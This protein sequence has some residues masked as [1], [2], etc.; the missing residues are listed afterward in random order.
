MW[1][2]TL[3][4]GTVAFALAPAPARAELIAA[5]DRPGPGGDLDIALVA[6]TTG[7]QIA[8]PA[9]I[10]TSADE[11]HP[12]LSGDG[13]LLTFERATPAGT[14]YAGADANAAKADPLPPF[15][16]ASQP[17]KQILVVDIHSGAR[18]QPTVL[19]LA[20]RKKITPALSSDAR[21]LIHG[22]TTGGE[23][24]SARVT[25]FDVSGAP[26]VPPETQIDRTD[27]HNALQSPAIGTGA[28]PLLA[29]S[30]LQERLGPEMPLSMAAGFDPAVGGVLAP[31]FKELDRGTDEGDNHP[32]ILSNRFVAYEQTPFST[33]SG[34][35][36]SGDIRGFDVAT[37]QPLTLVPGVNT[38]GDERMPA[39][40]AD[41]R[42]FTWVHHRADDDHDEL[43]TYDFATG[44]L[45][46][47][48]PADLGANPSRTSSGIFRR[49]QGNVSIADD[50]TLTRQVILVGTSTVVCHYVATGGGSPPPPKGGAPVVIERVVYTQVCTLKFGVRVAGTTVKVGFLVQRI[51]GLRHR[52]GKRRY[53]LR[54][55][56]RIP[57]GRHH[58]RF[59]GHRA[60]RFG[61]RGLPPDHYLITGRTFGRNGRIGGLAK[62]RVVVVR[63]PPRSN[64]RPVPSQG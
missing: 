50:P 41:G 55:V 45:V 29:F 33:S 1:R 16:D 9:G 4:V 30:E 57:L 17:D 54:R 51:V 39:W 2:L 38:G 28:R 12:S 59:H 14:A 42:Y 53:V 23:A 32:A 7:E 3:V 48:T 49:L 36:G 62:P 46:N 22:A 58:G 63:R 35:N 8:L 26:N 20:D 61:K 6:A 40:S 19:A 25:V 24:P 13:R 11:F 10:N 21:W 15:D 43:F 52:L 64:V 37:G 5:Y 18:V 44:Q 31:R 27:F 34:F 60:F 56:G 47:P